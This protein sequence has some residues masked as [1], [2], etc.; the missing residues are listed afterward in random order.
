MKRKTIGPITSCLECYHLKGDCC[1]H[2]D[3]FGRTLPE[4]VCG[5]PDW[6]PLPDYE[7][8]ENEVDE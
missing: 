3:C 1:T 6:C 4:D 5:F 7:E 8:P 2:E